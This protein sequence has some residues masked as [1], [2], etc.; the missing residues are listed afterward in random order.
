Q[1]GGVDL[2]EDPLI[3][4]AELENVLE[5]VFHDQRYAHV[6]RDRDDMPE[7]LYGRLEAA[8]HAAARSAEL[9]HGATKDAA[10]LQ[11]P[12][13]VSRIGC[14]VHLAGGVKGREMH[15]NRG[16]ADLEET[17][18]IALEIGGRDGARIP[19]HEFDI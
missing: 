9:D 16:Q 18:A 2:R 5:V 7:D 15:G 8:F 13:E 12:E 3:V 4:L 19:T 11:H 6:L 14:R 1:I 17:A 10:G